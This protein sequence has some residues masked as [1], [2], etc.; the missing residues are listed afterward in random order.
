VRCSLVTAWDSREF[1]SGEKTLTSPLDGL[2][3]PITAISSNGQKSVTTAKPSPVPSI[4]R[5]AA[6][7]MACIRKR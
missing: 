7:S 2:S 6:V 5:H 1:S 4:S 3:V